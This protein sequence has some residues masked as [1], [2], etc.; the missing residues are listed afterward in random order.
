M[1]VNGS[2]GSQLGHQ[3]DIGNLNDNNELVQLGGVGAIHLPNVVENVIFHVTSTVMQLLKM[4]ELFEGLAHE[5]PHDHIRNFV[6]VCGPFSFKNISQ[7]SVCLRLFPF[8]LIGEATK[9][10]ADLPRDSITSWDE[11][12]RPST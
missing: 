3:D 6:D 10:L 4:K 9:W 8:S 12:T 7:E 11:L 1:S 5:D 2:N